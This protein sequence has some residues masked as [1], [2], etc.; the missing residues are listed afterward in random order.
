VLKLLPILC[1]FWWSSYCSALQLREPES[2][3]IEA[4]T[5]FEYDLSREVVASVTGE[6]DFSLVEAP[7]WLRL[8]RARL[9]GTPLPKDVGPQVISF[10]ARE[11]NLTSPPQ[12]GRLVL[13][14]F[15]NPQLPSELDLGEVEERKS[16]ELNLRTRTKHPASETLAY[17][18]HPK[19]ELPPW[20]Q[21][22][23]D[24]LLSGVPTR[25]HIGEKFDFRIWVISNYGGKAETRVRGRVK[26]VP[27][28]IRWTQ[29]QFDLPPAKEDAPY[30][31]EISS[32]EW[33][34][35]PES[36]RIRFRFLDPAAAWP[37]LAW[38]GTL[39]GVPKRK[40]ILKK[41]YDVE[42][43]ATV[44]GQT[45]KSIAKFNLFTERVNKPPRWIEPAVE[46]PSAVS[47][48]QYE[49]KDLAKSAAD[50]DEDK[51]KFEIVPNSGPEWLQLTAEGLIRANIRPQ[52]TGKHR[53]KVLV[54]DSE[55][56]AQTT[57]SLT[58]SNDAPTWK[59]PSGK[60]VD[61]QQSQPY[62]LDLLSI[63]QDPNKD[64]LEFTAKRLPKWLS[65]NG[66]KLVGNPER[67]DVG[68]HSVQLV[69][70]DGHSA[71]S[72][73]ANIT[74]LLKAYPPEPAKNLPKLSMKERSEL[75]LNLS[76]PRFV[77]DPNGDTLNF[78]WDTK[79]P[80][81]AKLGS[82]GQL[83]LLPQLAQVGLQSL[84][85]QISDGKFS[86][87]L[88][89]DIE[90][91]RDPRPAQW[92]DAPIAFKTK[93]REPF[94]ANLQKQVRDLDNLPIRFLR[95]RG[96]DWL[97]V[98]PA[99]ELSATPPDSAQGKNIFTIVADNG[100]VAAEKSVEIEVDFKNHPPEIRAESLVFEI[101]E[102]SLL[103]QDLARSRFTSDTDATDPR[104]FAMEKPSDW[105][106]LTP[107]GKLDLAPGFKHIG[108]HVLA[109]TVSDNTDKVR[110]EIHVT[111]ARDPRPPEWAK[112][113][114]LLETLSRDPFRVDLHQHVKDLDGLKLSFEKR[115]GTEIFNVTSEGILTGQPTDAQVGDYT[116]KVLAA[117]DLNSA[118]VRLTVRVTFK[119][120]PP[121]WK[122]NNIALP[123]GRVGTLYSSSFAEHAEDIDTFQNL[124]FSKVSGP[125]WIIVDP[126]GKLFGTPS[127][128]D[129][130]QNT[131]QVR[132]DDGAGG[133]ALATVTLNID[134][135]NSAPKSQNGGTMQLPAAFQGELF[136]FT[137]APLFK[138]EQGDKLTFR[139]IFGPAWL[140]VNPTGEVT[141]VPGP[142]S[143]GQY[144]VIFE[145]HD[146]TS[147]TQ[148][149]AQG[150]VKN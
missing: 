25:P 112:E 83:T 124:R 21:L 136:L 93:A 45:F 118:M 4:G 141:G 117:N 64:P 106:K 147:G 88:K 16:L 99:G 81:W 31:A 128:S 144:H 1:I 54:K 133:S 48:Q 70:S 78:R 101:K 49:Y 123:P 7:G 130:G 46:L 119:N 108:K 61:A 60:L 122:K 34:E 114:I 131:V 58:V 55:F 87:P 53:W 129:T 115:S 134:R 76:E 33:I 37:E 135:E 107:A 36:A 10:R 113:E 138:D 95:K 102:R 142:D 47:N 137:L 82:D 42:A 143:F 80:E 2:V 28:S 23:A 65:L 97:Q 26:K 116:L 59:L 149:K 86:V 41:T 90:I 92:A 73:Q 85:V 121:R 14:V 145:V 139:K 125:P 109:F 15:V 3:S 77:T 30:R 66:T 56:S 100:L 35:N 63:A 27:V 84:Q 8:D 140:R 67:P 110:G 103:T 127:P 96:P 79:A 9:F 6:I 17:R 98:D 38:D 12:T 148:I 39:R 32:P 89:L 50:V 5:S 146:G 13:N 62:T 74:V 75:K 126:S 51:L 24:G 29:K 104:I 69:V 52:H 91:L 120:T 20:L 11:K 71:N 132:V 40:D 72:L 43:E 19:D 57:L 18:V 105:A 111:V 22:R 94:K 68:E 150:L 44:D